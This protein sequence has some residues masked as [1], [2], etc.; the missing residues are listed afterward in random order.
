VLKVI[1]IYSVNRSTVDG[2]PA[3]KKRRLRKHQTDFLT[4]GFT[5]QLVNGEERPQC[6]MCGEVLANNSFNA[7]NLRKHLTTKHESL[8]N[9]PLQFFE[10]KLLE[11]RKQSN[12]MRTAT[13]AFLASFEVS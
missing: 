5:Y 8:V 4:F 9:K 11:I 2:S 6:V 3:E 7:R 1:S 10:R 13:K 12:L